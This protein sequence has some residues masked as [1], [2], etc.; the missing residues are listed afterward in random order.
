MCGRKYSKDEL[1][2]A[3]Y[4]E[5]LEIIGPDTPP[6]ADNFQPNYNIAP[7]HQVP[8]ARAVSGEDGTR[9]V[10]LERLQWGLVPL[11]AKDTKIGYKMINARAETLAEKPSF[12]TLLAGHRCVIP[13]SGFY[14]WQRG[15]G[16]SGKDRQAHRVAR[17][18]GGTM[19]LAGLWTHHAGMDLSTYSVITTAA[20]PDFMAVH[21]RLPMILERGEVSRWLEADWDDAKAL[22]RPYSGALDPVP[23]SNAVGKVANNYPELLA[24]L[25]PGSGAAQQAL[26]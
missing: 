22:A 17:G 16:P 5:V 6:P 8:V 20:T 10:V 3:E 19:L 15:L 25:P 24:P 11:W 13:V 18:D 14:E 4:R 26:L 9:R 12:R 23:I 7:T 1:N 2:W 21:H